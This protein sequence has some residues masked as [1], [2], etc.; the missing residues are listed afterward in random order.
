MNYTY[1]LARTDTS[2]SLAAACCL[3]NPV[4]VLRVAYCSSTQPAAA[5]PA[6]AII[7]HRRA[8]LPTCKREPGSTV[9]HTRAKHNV[10]SGAAVCVAC[11]QH[12]STPI[13]CQLLHCKSISDRIFAGLEIANYK[14]SVREL[15]TANS[16]LEYSHNNKLMVENCLFYF[17]NTG[18]FPSNT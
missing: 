1:V 12:N 4:V 3:I 10:R 18:S 16:N 6:A 11:R 2:S 14:C 5:G 17:L 8:Q 7:M 15:T 9:L 13:P